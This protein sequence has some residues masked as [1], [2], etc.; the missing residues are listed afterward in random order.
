MGAYQESYLEAQERR[1]KLAFVAAT[2]PSELLPLPE[3]STV[4]DD[5]DAAIKLALR[6]YGLLQW[7]S[8]NSGAY[9]TFGRSRDGGKYL[10]TLTNAAGSKLYV[11]GKD[12]AELEYELWKAGLTVNGEE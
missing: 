4:L 6:L 8:E 1:K 5:N 7:L 10:I 11:G 2:V 3:L 12:V 9:A